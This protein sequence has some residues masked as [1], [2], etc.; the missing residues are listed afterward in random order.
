MTLTLYCAAFYNFPVPLPHFMMP[1]GTR[2][3]D[4]KIGDFKMG[5]FKLA[6][7]AGASI[8]PITILGTFRLL[9]TLADTF[10]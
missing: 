2:S 6:H 1:I 4:G 3:T 7:D 8:V 9:S 10:S 5:A